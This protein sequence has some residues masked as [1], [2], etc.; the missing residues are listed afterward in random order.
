MVKFLQVCNF[1]YS[2][3]FVLV[4]LL[5][6]E[7]CTG[8][9]TNS[10]PNV[11]DGAKRKIDSKSS[12][13]RPGEM[14]KNSPSCTAQTSCGRFEPEK[15]NNVPHALLFHVQQCSTH[16]GSLQRLLR[17]PLLRFDA[18][19]LQ[20]TTTHLGKSPAALPH[21]RHLHSCC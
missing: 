13:W 2:A 17:S 19:G 4:F 1:H 10:D 14:P 7:I 20:N 5:N 6:A 8:I 3:S 11:Q 12:R 15:K 21:K 18:S 16:M 9:K